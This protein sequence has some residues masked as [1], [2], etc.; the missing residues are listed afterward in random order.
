[1]SSVQIDLNNEMVELRSFMTSKLE[2]NRQIMSE[3]E[4][5]T[6]DRLD[7]RGSRATS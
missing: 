6:M 2:E 7:N 1:M 5:M 4:E 3:F